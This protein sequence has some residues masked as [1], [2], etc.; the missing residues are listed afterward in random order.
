MVEKEGTTTK[1]FTTTDI[2]IQKELQSIISELEGRRDDA[3]TDDLEDIVD[4][5]AFSIYNEC[6]N[7]I[8]RHISKLGSVKEDK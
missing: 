3:K 4:G 5:V 2:A 6:I 8:Y 1:E 7:T